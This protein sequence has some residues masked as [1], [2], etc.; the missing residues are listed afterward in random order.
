MFVSGSTPEESIFRFKGL[1]K[2]LPLGGGFPLLYFGSIP[3]FQ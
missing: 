1:G 3:I 2:G